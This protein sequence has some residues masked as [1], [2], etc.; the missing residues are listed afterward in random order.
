MVSHRST[1]LTVS[2]IYCTDHPEIRDEE[3]LRFLLE[4]DGCLDHQFG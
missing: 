3:H 1:G 2:R 4:Q